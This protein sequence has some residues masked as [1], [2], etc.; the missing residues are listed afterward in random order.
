MFSRASKQEPGRSKAVT[1]AV[2][3]ARGAVVVDAGRVNSAEERL[4]SLRVFR[5]DALGVPGAVAVDVLDGLLKRRYLGSSPLPLSPKHEAL[6]SNTE[7]NRTKEKPKANL[8]KS[9]SKAPAA[10]LT[11]IVWHRNSVS[12]S[13]SCTGSESSAGRCGRQTA[14]GCFVG[15]L[16]ANPK[17]GCRILKSLES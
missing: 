6:C 14:S 1:E 12:K 10:A 8:F 16:G 2:C 9:E 17:E 13:S 4:C 5:H 11:A 15:T 3:K 7:R